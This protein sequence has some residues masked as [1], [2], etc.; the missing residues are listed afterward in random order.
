MVISTNIRY[1]GRSRA[2]LR[3]RDGDRFYRRV[4]NVNS[5]Y[6]GF[7]F[8]VYDLITG[9]LLH[10]FVVTATDEEV[11]DDT[12]RLIVGGVVNVYSLSTYILGLG[13]M[14]KKKILIFNLIFN[15]VFKRT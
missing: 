14:A 2:S 11:Q 5:E 15:R 7:F 8:S 6:E 9:D 4:E 1:G 12:L 10:K 13:N 3:S